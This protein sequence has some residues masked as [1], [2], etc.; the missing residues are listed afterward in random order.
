MTTNVL[1]ADCCNAKPA[2]RVVLAGPRADGGNPEL[3]FCGH[4]FRLHRSALASREPLVFD[5][6]NRFVDA[7]A[8]LL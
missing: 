1:A 6:E 8:V 2:F 3:L 4:H 7:S 5:T